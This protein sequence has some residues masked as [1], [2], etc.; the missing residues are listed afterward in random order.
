MDTDE[1]IV[2][3]AAISAC[4]ATIYQRR[5]GTKKVG[6][7][8]IQPAFRRAALIHPKSTSAWRHCSLGS[9]YELR[10]RPKR[11]GWARTVDAEAV[12]EEAVE[13]QGELA[14]RFCGGC[15]HAL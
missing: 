13:L 6:Q 14:L 8:R 9:R 5:K 11:V 3:C 7:K 1:L 10:H 15:G 4:C 2:L 12:R